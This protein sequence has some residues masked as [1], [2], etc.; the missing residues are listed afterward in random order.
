MSWSLTDTGLD[1]FLS[2]HFFFLPIYLPSVSVSFCVC[3]YCYLLHIRR[4]RLE[5]LPALLGVYFSLRP[6]ISATAF[7]LHDISSTCLL[8]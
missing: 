2:S 3:Y 7:L 8:S 6:S 5:L 1:C 4:Y